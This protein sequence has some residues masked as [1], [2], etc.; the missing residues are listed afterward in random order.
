MTVPHPVGALENS[1]ERGAGGLV[2]VNN[3]EH[4]AWEPFGTHPGEVE[5][6]TIEEPV[7]SLRMLTAILALVYFGG[8]VVLQEIFGRFTG[9]Q[10]SPLVTV[11]ST[12]GI[13]ALFNP[14]R[15]RTQ[16]WIDRRFYRSKYDAE[17]ALAGF[18]LVARDEVDIDLL[19]TSML[20]VVQDAMQPESVSI[21]MKAD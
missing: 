3:C 8:V 17:M 12:L 2:D 1:G 10:S 16:D 9:E 15:R 14:L 19:T 6:K 5:R 21:W 7:L 4:D 20:A 18:A 13:A 11:V